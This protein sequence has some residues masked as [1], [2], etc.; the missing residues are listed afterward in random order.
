MT[1]IHYCTIQDV[2]IALKI[3]CALPIHPFPSSQTQAPTHLFTVSIVLPFPECHIVEIIQHGA[4][5]GWLLSLSH[6][7]LS[8]LHVFSWLGNSFFRAEKYSI[9]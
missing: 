8:F 4:F 5:S 9:V 7:H 2:F 6:M 1:Y 3:L